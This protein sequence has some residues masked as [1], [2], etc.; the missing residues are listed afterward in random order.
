MV[1]QG[2]IPGRLPER[3]VQ[4]VPPSRLSWTRPSLLPDQISPGLS[5]DSAIE[6]TPP[7]YSTPMVAGVSPPEM[8]W[9]L[10]SFRVRSGLI[11][12]QVWPPSVVTWMYWL[13]TYTLL[14]SWGEMV[15]GKFHTKRYLRL[16]AGEP[17]GAS[18]QTSTFRA[19]PVRT[20]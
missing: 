12:F 16:A 8:P 13:P 14:W 4:V 5:R 7:A 3:L 2:G 18:G 17:I 11:S 9:R 1:P 20:S 10:L 6:N 15:R 19:I